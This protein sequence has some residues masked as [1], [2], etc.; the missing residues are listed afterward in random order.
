M[1]AEMNKGVGTP[2]SGTREKTPPR[3]FWSR[4]IRK[5]RHAIKRDRYEP[6]RHYMR[7]PGPAS[8]QR[9]SGAEDPAE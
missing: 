8:S 4:L 9:S 6:A 1:V 2:Q 5:I 3:G 7:G